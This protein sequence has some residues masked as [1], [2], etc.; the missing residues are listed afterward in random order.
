M[1]FVMRGSYSDESNGLFINKWRHTIAM[2][3]KSESL[4]LPH[5]LATKFS[6]L[7]Y[8]AYI[9]YNPHVNVASLIK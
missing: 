5:Y 4:P 2:A 1:A 9:Y 8:S 6:M 3:T 7:I